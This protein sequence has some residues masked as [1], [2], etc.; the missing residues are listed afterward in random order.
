MAADFWQ[1]VNGLIST[2]IPRGVDDELE[3]ILD[4]LLLLT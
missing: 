2:D 3:A 4:S 1:L